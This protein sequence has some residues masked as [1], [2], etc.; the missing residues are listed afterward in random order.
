MQL[1]ELKTTDGTRK[2]FYEKAFVQIDNDGTKTLFSYLT[3]IVKQSPDGTLSKLYEKEP[4]QTTWRHIKAFLNITKKK[5]S[6]LPLA[7]EA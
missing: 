7:K 2:S 4:T 6:S 3:P 5:W 1:C